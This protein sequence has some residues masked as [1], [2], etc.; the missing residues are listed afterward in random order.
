MDAGEE[1][2]RIVNTIV[3][4]KLVQIDLNIAISSVDLGIYYKKKPRLVGTFIKGVLTE[5][6]LDSIEAREE[7]EREE[8]KLLLG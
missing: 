5:V 7:K 3:N 4:G 8:Q 1:R 6:N 2:P